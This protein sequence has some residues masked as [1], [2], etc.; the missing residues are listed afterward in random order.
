LKD[1]AVD[2]YA[3]L[4]RLFAKVAFNATEH[5]LKLAFRIVASG[6]SPSGHGVAFF[7]E[8]LAPVLSSFGEAYQRA[9]GFD[10]A[11]LRQ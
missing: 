4:M 7:R 6:N 10:A 3:T 2:A 11:P 8:L 9:I 1:Y 5:R